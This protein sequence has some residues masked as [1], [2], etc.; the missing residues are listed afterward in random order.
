MGYKVTFEYLTELPS[1]IWPEGMCYDTNNNI[2]VLNTRDASYNKRTYEIDLDG[3][4]SLT[5]GPVGTW[6]NNLATIY[7]ED[8]DEIINYGGWRPSTRSNRTYKYTG[9]GWTN[10]VNGPRNIDANGMCYNPNDK[11]IYTYGG[12][13]SFNNDLYAF[14][15]TSWSL[16]DGGSDPGRRAFLPMGWDGVNEKLMIFA[17]FTGYGPSANTN[18][19][20]HNGGTSWDTIT[21]SGDWPGAR[22]YH[23][24]VW[25]PGIQKTV[26]FC[27]LQEEPT[28][29]WRED[30]W[31]WDGS[32]WEEIDISATLPD[33]Y[34]YG[35]YQ[36]MCYVPDWDCMVVWRR[37]ATTGIR[38]AYK[39][40]IKDNQLFKTL[41]EDSFSGQM[42]YPT[43]NYKVAITNRVYIESVNIVYNK[44]YESKLTGL[45]RVK[46]QIH[47]PDSNNSIVDI[48]ITF[49]G[50]APRQ[51][52]N[53]MIQLARAINGSGMDIDFCDDFGTNKIYRGKWIN[54]NDFVESSELLTG[55]TM[56]ISCYYLEDV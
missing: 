5:Y 18:V 17:G 8:R 31:L 13:S 19:Y 4:V 20:L 7:N 30:L 11:L 34:L 45:E 53:Q 38:T 37:N 51:F 52:T 39:L 46:H 43:A 54:A 56:H 48:F 14:N 2:F 1:G 47:T 25:H 26:L 3:N 55:G 24:L 15:G 27:G 12:A 50:N 9:S 21:P 33:S 32:S 44:K 49:V 10:I 28:I 40:R 36:T 41:F 35:N 42:I 23:S 22:G 6:S 29:I 16:V